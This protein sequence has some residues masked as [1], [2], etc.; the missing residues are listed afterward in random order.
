MQALEE[1][2]G[3]RPDKPSLLKHMAVTVGAHPTGARHGP[4]SVDVARGAQSHLGEI[5]IELLG[6]EERDISSVALKNR[7][8]E[9]VG[10]TPGVSSL[11]FMAEFMSTGNAIEVELSH[12]NFDTLLAASEELKGT[13]RDY[14]GVSDIAD[15]FE[16]G[17]VELK[18]D[19]K[20]LLA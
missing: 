1:F 8:R 10:E 16:P 13:L 4:V 6:S 11:T 7:W 5:N 20:V 15:D 12:Q 17:K 14:A 19:L 18:L 2:D 3:E 9:L